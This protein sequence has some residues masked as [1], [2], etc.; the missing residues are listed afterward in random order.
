VCGRFHRNQ[1]VCIH[2][3]GQVDSMTQATLVLAVALQPG[4]L[5]AWLI[6]GLVAGFVASRLVGGSGYGL[7]G[8]IILGIVGAFIGGFIVSLFIS[9]STGLIGSIIVA[10][11]GAVILILLLRAVRRA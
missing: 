9:G 2:F 5:L 11:I 1:R 3:E 8:D 4:G 7:I 6:V 10:I